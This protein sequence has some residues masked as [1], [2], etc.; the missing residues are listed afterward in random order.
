MNRVKFN[1][2]GVDSKIQ[3]KMLEDQMRLRNLE[4]EYDL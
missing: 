2:S 4:S 3:G 1:D